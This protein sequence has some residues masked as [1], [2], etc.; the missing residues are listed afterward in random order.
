MHHEALSA[1]L[2]ASLFAVHL[3]RNSLLA[4]MFLQQYKVTSPTDLMIDKMLR[5]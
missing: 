5:I 2:F 4:C 1:I 3:G